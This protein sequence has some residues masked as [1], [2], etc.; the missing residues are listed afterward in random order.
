MIVNKRI[1]TILISVL[2][3]AVVVLL[4]AFTNS[5]SAKADATAPLP[6][7]SFAVNEDGHTYGNADQVEELGYF[8]DLLSVVCE[9]GTV[10]YA[11]YSDITGVQPKTPEEALRL[12]EANGGK[13]RT[14]PVYKFDGKTVIGQYIIHGID[15]KDMNVK[16]YYSS[17]N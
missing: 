8:P 15:P 7:A 5:A 13:D 1:T 11:Y 2:I 12:Q 16:Y 3:L 9:D 10:G 17:A 6:T 14:I 4:I